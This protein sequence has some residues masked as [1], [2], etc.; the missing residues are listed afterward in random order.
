VKVRGESAS[1]VATALG[2]PSLVN[3]YKKMNRVLAW[4]GQEGRGAPGES[5]L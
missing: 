2:I 4:L 3:F 1:D 5:S